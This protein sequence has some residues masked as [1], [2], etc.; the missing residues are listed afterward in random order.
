MSQSREKDFTDRWTEL[1]SQDPP[2]ETTVKNDFAQ[3]HSN[4][5]LGK[6]MSDGWRK[7]R[8]NWDEVFKNGASKTCGRLPFYFQDCL[9]Q[10]LLGPFLNILS[11]L[12][13]S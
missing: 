13:P 10:I 6:E 12:L 9:P 2:A 8:N 1:N 3:S 4:I 7:M 5:M 11:N